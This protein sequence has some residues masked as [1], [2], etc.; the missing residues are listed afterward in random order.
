VLDRRALTVALQHL[1]HERPE[2]ALSLLKAWP[3]GDR[4]VDQ[5]LRMLLS[6][7]WSVR[8][9]ALSA[10]E[11]RGVVTD[12]DRRAVAMLDV[13][14][15]EACERRLAGLQVLA[16]LAY[17]EDALRAVDNARS[18]DPGARCLQRHLDGAERDIAARIDVR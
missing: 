2:R 14:G 4:G 7:A 9:H 11:S 15:T 3:Q 5:A 1:H 18:T 12:D 13:T 6:D 8:H 17:D 16:R 10:L